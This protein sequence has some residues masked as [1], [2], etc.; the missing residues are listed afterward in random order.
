MLPSFPPKNVSLI[1]NDSLNAAYSSPDQTSRI[2]CSMNRAAFCDTLMSRR[3]F[4]MLLTPFRLV[5]SK[6]MAKIHL[7]RGRFDFCRAV[8]ILTA[9]GFWQPLQ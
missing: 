9:N 3:S 6:W 4:I 5:I 1:S 2:R 8:P 7:R